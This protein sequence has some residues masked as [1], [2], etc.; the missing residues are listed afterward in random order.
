MSALLTMPAITS[1]ALSALEAQLAAEPTRAD[2]LYGLSSVY[3]GPWCATKPLQVY[4]KFPRTEQQRVARM[5]KYVNWKRQ[6]IREKHAIH[7]KMGG[8]IAAFLIL[9]VPVLIALASVL[10]SWALKA[11]IG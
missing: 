9:G 4:G 1:A 3:A 6:K 10:W 7:W 2:V 11:A 8:A 5:D